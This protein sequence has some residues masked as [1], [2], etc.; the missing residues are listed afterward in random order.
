MPGRGPAAGAA[1]VVLVAGADDDSAL[2]PPIVM[3]P[4]L[5][6]ATVSNDMEFRNSF[7]CMTSS[8]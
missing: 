3:Q 5:K 7:R 1:A 8:R 6:A 2:P 4:V